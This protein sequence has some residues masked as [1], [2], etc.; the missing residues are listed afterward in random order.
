MSSDDVVKVN[1]Y[2]FLQGIFNEMKKENIW[3]QIIQELFGEENIT[4]FKD[5]I[6]CISDEKNGFQ[7]RVSLQFLTCSCKNRMDFCRLWSWMKEMHQYL[8]NFLISAFDA[9]LKLEDLT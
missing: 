1:K 7:C 6:K 8:S 4:K 9:E 2:D 5:K 3:K